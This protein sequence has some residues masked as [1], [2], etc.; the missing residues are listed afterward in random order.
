MVLSSAAELVSVAD[1]LS[2]V[3]ELSVASELV[4]TAEVVRVVAASTEE[5]GVELPATSELVPAGSSLE[6]LLVSAGAL[7]L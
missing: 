7:E 4:G 1:G 3:L 5:L 2:V 6:V